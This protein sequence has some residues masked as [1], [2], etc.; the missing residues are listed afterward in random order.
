MDNNK[1]NDKKNKS[2]STIEAKIKEREKK[3]LT[4]ERMQLII[5]DI[6][7]IKKPKK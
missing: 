1:K 4:Q 2:E 6:G 3:R 7:K 5:T